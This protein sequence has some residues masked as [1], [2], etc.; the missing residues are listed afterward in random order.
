MQ[1]AIEIK[2]GDL[3]LRGMLHTP[4]AIKG[5]IPIVLILHGFQGNKTGPHFIFVK[6]SRILESK[7]IASVRFDF[8]GSGESDGDFINMTLSGELEEAGYML[9]YIKTLEF[10]DKDRIGVIGLSMGGAVASMLAGKR[11]DEIH[12]LC[13]W[14]PAGNMGEIVLNYYIGGNYAQ[15]KERG[16]YDIEG[17]LIGEDF[18]TDVTELDIYQ[19]ASDFDKK[20]LLIHGDHDTIVPLSTSER[21]LDYYG[22]KAKLNIISGADHTFDKNVWEAEVNKITAGFFTDMLQT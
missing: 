5:K 1:K 4:D 22:K 9:D 14:A 19:K 3:T 20:V 21:Y 10:V 16:C 15:F 17:F 18:V 11:K 2:S 7:G 8:G 6:L 12:A 13:L